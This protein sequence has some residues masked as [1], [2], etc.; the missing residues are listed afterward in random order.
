MQWLILCAQP[1]VVD[2]L[3]NILKIE[4]FDHE[5]VFKVNTNVLTLEYKYRKKKSSKKLFP[6]RN[7]P[8]TDT[9]TTSRFLTL[10]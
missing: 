9:I 5:E 4:N 1:L 8:A 2:A 10:S 6:L 7:A 3:M